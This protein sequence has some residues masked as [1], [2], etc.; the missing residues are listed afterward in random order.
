LIQRSNSTNPF[1]ITSDPNGEVWVI[2][3]TD[4]GFEGETVLYYNSISLKF[5]EL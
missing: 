2:I 4:S 1:R 5:Q 3:G